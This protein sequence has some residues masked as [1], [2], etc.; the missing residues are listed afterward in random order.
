MSPVRVERPRRLALLLGAAVLL[1][2][3]GSA[4]AWN[5][6]AVRRRR[7]PAA[8]PGAGRTWRV[9]RSNGRN[10]GRATVLSRL[11]VG[12]RQYRDRPADRARPPAE[13]RPGAHDSPTTD[14]AERRDDSI[15]SPCGRGCA[16]SAP[17]TTRTGTC[18]ASCATSCGRAKGARLMRDR[19]TGFCLGDRYRVAYPLPGRPSA[20]RFGERCGKGA[21][22]LLA[23]REGISIGW[24]DNYN[25]HLEGQEFEVTSL[26]PGRYVLVHR[27][28]PGRDF[29]RERLHRQRGVDGARPQLAPRPEAAAADRRRRPLPANGDLPLGRPGADRPSRLRKRGGRWAGLDRK[30][31]GADDRRPCCLNTTGIC[32]SRGRGCIEPVPVRWVAALRVIVSALVLVPAAASA[33]NTKFVSKQYG[34]S[35]VLPGNSSRWFSS[36]ARVMWSTGTIS[37]DTRCLRHLHRSARP[38]GCTSWGRDGFQRDPPWKSGRRSSSGIAG[39]TARHTPRSRTRSSPGRRRASSRGRARTATT[40]SG[41]PRSTRTSAT[42]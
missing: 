33:P 25:P 40:Q 39:Q 13:R 1:V 14:R 41:S 3:V 21:P 4:V 34:F 12:S 42:S 8:E 36:F 7:R 15:G 26:P 37:P 30:R 16:T 22:R 18:S 10:N 28:N 20:P 31:R 11:R 2:I 35:I 17:L 6:A 24:G 29:R 19:K 27:V 38:T 9:E 32:R 23:I 5:L